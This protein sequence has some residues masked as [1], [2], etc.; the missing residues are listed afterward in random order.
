MDEA[1]QQDEAAHLARIEEARRI[2]AGPI[3]FL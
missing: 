1:E 3:T 2:F